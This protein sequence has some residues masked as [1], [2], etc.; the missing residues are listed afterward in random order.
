M[1]TFLNRARSL[2]GYR[3]A[4]SNEGTNLVSASIATATDHQRSI[5]LYPS[6]TMNLTIFG[7]P[8]W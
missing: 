5:G 6:E 7:L 4:M 1:D 3:L 8:T 2:G